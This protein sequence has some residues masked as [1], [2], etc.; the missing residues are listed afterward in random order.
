MVICGIHLI[1]TNKISYTQSIFESI[2]IKFFDE[3][4]T[5]NF[6]VRISLTIFLILKNGLIDCHVNYVQ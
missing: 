4:V 5:K 1:E 6:F 3:K 2:H